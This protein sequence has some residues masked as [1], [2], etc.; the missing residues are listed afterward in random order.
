MKEGKGGKHYDKDE[1]LHIFT[2]F[3]KV[4]L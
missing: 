2:Y 3:I 1:F 4:I